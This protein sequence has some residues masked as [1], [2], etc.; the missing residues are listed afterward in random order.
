MTEWQESALENNQK[1][2]TTP[3]RKDRCT[4][5][6]GTGYWSDFI[7]MSIPTQTKI[8]LSK[9]KDLEKILKE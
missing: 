5:E 4:P 7:N 6:K 9:E 1:P 3:K 8:I 2:S